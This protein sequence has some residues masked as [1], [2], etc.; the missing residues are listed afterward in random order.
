MSCRMA[1]QCSLEGVR[2]R[3]RG[4]SSWNTHDSN[5]PSWAACS[6]SCSP[7]E[8]CKS[9][10]A[11]FGEEYGVRRI[12]DLIAR[13]VVSRRNVNVGATQSRGPSKDVN[14]TTE[15][16]DLQVTTELRCMLVPT[17]TCDKSCEFNP[18]DAPK[19]PVPRHL[20]PHI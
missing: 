14:A 17:K 8:Q 10:C 2:Q 9:E 15:R 3:Q 5:E 19:L 13:P 7:V 20:Q 4:S 1:G 12:L 18:P 11:A 6:S 16:Q